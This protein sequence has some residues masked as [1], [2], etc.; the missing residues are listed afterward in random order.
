MA[1]IPMWLIGRAI[2]TCSLTPCTLG[3]DGTLTEGTGATLIGRLDEVQ[4]ASRNTLENISPMDC[5]QANNVIT[6]SDTTFTLTEIMQNASNASVD[7]VLSLMAYGYDYAKVVLA[8]DGKTYTF[9]G[10]VGDYG[11]TIRKGKCTATLSLH[12]VAISNGINGTSAPS[13]SSNPAFV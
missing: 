2:T 4:V 12:Q 8:R 10:V 13:Y 5:R 9:Y 6:E 7:N 3:S 1:K 11:E